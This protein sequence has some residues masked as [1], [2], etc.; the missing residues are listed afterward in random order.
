MNQVNG[1]PEMQMLRFCLPQ[2]KAAFFVV[3]LVFLATG[4]TGTRSFLIKKS[5]ISN[6]TTLG[7]S[8]SLDRAIRLSGKY[9]L[10]VRY[11][12]YNVLV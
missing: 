4:T 8:H 12:N 3:I 1:I 5:G 10:F 11:R 2:T 6:H 9:I 7:A